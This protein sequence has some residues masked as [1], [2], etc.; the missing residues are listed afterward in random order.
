MGNTFFT[1]DWH[2]GHG[3]VMTFDE[4]P[5]ENLKDM[6]EQLIQ[7]WN[8]KVTDKDTVYCLG[9]MFWCDDIK[10]KAIIKSLK[11]DKILI[12]G[13]HTKGIKNQENRK[14][15]K[16]IVDYKE[17]NLDKTLIIMSHYPIFSWKGMR[18]GSIHLYGHL[19]NTQEQRLYEQHIKMMRSYDIQFDAYNVGCMMPYMNYEPQDLDTII[20]GAEEYYKTALS[21][22]PI[23]PFKN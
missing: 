7:K 2:I 13:N 12:P 17:I 22:S 15:F 10:A 23:E 4:R 1:S 19:H 16:E 5:F 8:N 21:S 3:N 9:D 11:G 18:Y 14:L 6:E 20:D